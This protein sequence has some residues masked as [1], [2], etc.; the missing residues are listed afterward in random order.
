MAREGAPRGSAVELDPAFLGLLATSLG[1]SNVL[2]AQVYA[3]VGG[4]TLVDEAFGHADGARIE[5][6]TTRHRLPVAC[7]SK[8]LD[9]VALARLVESGQIRLDDTIADRWPTLAGTA[10]GEVTVRQLATH[11][12]GFV[13]DPC[14]ENPMAPWD[15]RTAE[16]LAA[17]GAGAAGTSARYTLLSAWQ[18]LAEL[19]VDA[20]G[21][22][23]AELMQREVLGP[24]GAD[25]I[26][27]TLVDGPDRRQAF[28][29]TTTGGHVPMAS[30]EWPQSKGPVWPGASCTS[31]L[32]S[33]ASI[34]ELILEDRTGS[35]RLLSPA[36]VSFLTG[37][38]RGS[39]YDP[40]LRSNCTW[41]LGVAHADSELL[42]SNAGHDA[43]GH[44][45]LGGIGLYAEPSTELVIGFAANCQLTRDELTSALDQV[46]SAVHPST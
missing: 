27:L 4:R 3:S 23:Y 20:T 14:M 11:S 29:R 34:Y 40:E 15:V 9:G 32:R 22:E 45:G 42:G 28:T 1:T 12:A 18:L 30:T 8:P 36:G 24:A 17:V 16:A 6:L 25:K 41:G 35:R 21:L 19:M 10:A 5:P 7:A 31:S 46:R 13:A 37:D 38:V 44:I 2:G 33:L 26:D 39:V 43:F